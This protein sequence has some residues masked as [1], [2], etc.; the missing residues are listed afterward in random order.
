MTRYRRGTHSRLCI[1]SGARRQND[2][3][4][5]GDA[6]MPLTS[7]RGGVSGDSSAT[8][9]STFS[10]APA[11]GFQPINVQVNARYVFHGSFSGTYAQ[12]SSNATTASRHLECFRRRV[13]SY[14]FTLIHMLYRVLLAPPFSP[15]LSKTTST[16]I[17]EMC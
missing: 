4:G 16:V 10:M 9:L 12:E 13:E 2:T 14:N 1:T 11:C 15:L 6:T 5:G 17:S 8:S 7:L 3:V